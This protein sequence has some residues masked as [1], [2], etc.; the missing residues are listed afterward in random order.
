MFSKFQQTASDHYSYYF[1][2]SEP[3]KVEKE[4]K[5]KAHPW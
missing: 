1:Q 2:L 3:A 4:E 5:G